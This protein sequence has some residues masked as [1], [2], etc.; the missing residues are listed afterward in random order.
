MDTNENYI[1]DQFC[2]YEISL[3]LK[4]LGFDE[5]CFGVYIETN[6]EPILR[7]NLPHLESQDKVNYIYERAILTPLW[8]QAIDFLETKG[9]Y[10]NITRV[11]QWSPLPI[12]F[13]GWCIYIG[14]ENPEEELEC[15]SYYVN[16]YYSTKQEAREQAIL[17]AIEIINGRSI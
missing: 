1:K 13:L 3:K 14:T 7:Y 2:S 11:F 12:K 17:K 8:Q 6:G 16:H 10:I 5:E 4:E 9:Y 15:N